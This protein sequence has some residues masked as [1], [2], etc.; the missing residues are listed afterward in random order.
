VYGQKIVP[1]LGVAALF[2]GAPTDIA[3]G[4][5]LVAV[6][7]GRAGVS[8]LS[9]FLVDEDGNLTLQAVTTIA[10]PINGVAIVTPA[11]GQDN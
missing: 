5:G 1:D 3:S 9:V 10:S 7:D 8:H 11:T 4:A 2:N 6:I